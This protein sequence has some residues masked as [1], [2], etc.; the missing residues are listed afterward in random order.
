[1]RENGLPTAGPWLINYT[2]PYEYVVTDS[3]GKPVRTFT[4]GFG[5][6]YDEG[7]ANAKLQAAAP[8]LRDTLDL[9]MQYIDGGMPQNFNN[10]MHVLQMARNVKLKLKVAA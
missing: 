10:K 3:N 8:E 9:L 7:L 1:M 2:S 6:A 5:C 4:N